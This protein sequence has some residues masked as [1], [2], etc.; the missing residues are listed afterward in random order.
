MRC[1]LHTRRARPHTRARCASLHLVG[2]DV[3]RAAERARVAVAVVG[4]PGRR[5]ALIAARRGRRQRLAVGGGHGG[6]GW[7][8]TLLKM[9]RDGLGPICARE[10]ETTDV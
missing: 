1:M 3:G 7:A 5:V 9:P 2:A 10:M 8:L 6:R 4:G